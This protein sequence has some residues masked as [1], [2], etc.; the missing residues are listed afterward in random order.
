MNA[1]STGWRRTLC[2]DDLPGVHDIQHRGAP[3]M[4][5][6]IKVPPLAIVTL[7]A[8]SPLAAQGPGTFDLF[9]SRRESPSQPIFGGISFAHYSGPIGLRFSGGLNFRGNDNTTQGLVSANSS[10][11][12]CRYYHCDGRRGPGGGRGEDFGGMSFLPTLGGWTADADLVVAPVR[13]VAPLRALL[14]GFS[15]YGFVGVG[16]YSVRPSN[17][18]DTTRATWSL[19]AGAHHQLIG[20]LGIGAEARYRQAF[21]SDSGIS[22]DWK[23]KLEYRANLT[24]S[25][26]GQKRSRPAPVTVAS[27]PTSVSP[28]SA[29]P[30]GEQA[31]AATID[32]RVASRVLDVADGLVDTP[33]R[34]GGDTPRSGFDA[35]G[36]VQYVFAKEGISL[37]GTVEE[38]SHSGTSIPMT[39]GSL[40]PG[41]LLFFSNDGTNPDHV[42]IYAGR[43][44]IIHSTASGNGVRYDTL[45]EGERGHWFA[46]HLVRARRVVAADASNGRSPRDDRNDNGDRAP[47]PARSGQ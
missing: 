47:R 11:Y 22:P 45:G 2:R 7:L 25:F 18:I 14:L 9:A 44:R 29:A 38:L 32:S 5:P 33:Y 46:D 26:G 21:K 24:I 15:P 40:R 35:G 8:A 3:V 39:I 31:P 23:H 41:D 37:P 28:C 4:Q 36:F 19:G 10:G 20:A 13:A 30:C 6:R 1:R 34:S 12:D 17:A 27:A 16:G 43:E 42:A